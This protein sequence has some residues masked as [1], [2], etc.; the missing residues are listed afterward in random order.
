MYFYRSVCALVGA[1]SIAACFDATAPAGPDDVAWPT[2]EYAA[3][4]GGGLKLSVFEA[5]GD[6]PPFGPGWWWVG[7]VREPRT[8]LALRTFSHWEWCGTRLEAEVEREG[9][10]TNVTVGRVISVPSI[11][12][13]I[14][15]LDPSASYRRFLPFS[16]GEH[17]L[18]IHVL[19]QVHEYRVL[20]SP[21]AIDLVRVTPRLPA[22]VLRHV[23]VDEELQ[24]FWRFPPRSAAVVCQAVSESEGCGAL[25]DG[26]AAEPGFE[27]HYFPRW[28]Q[29]PFSGRVTENAAIESAVLGP[30]SEV[31]FFRYADAEGFA[32]LRQF[33]CGAAP[34]GSGRGA[35]AFSWRN[36]EVHSYSSSC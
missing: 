6:S 33:L 24:T 7:G 36:E 27:R 12:S 25:F 34:W 19:G 15:G 9:A 3:V 35:I 14:G 21:A 11:C 8:V 10:V 5:P 13:A 26:L 22:S 16:E 30:T 29:T 28:G 1:L 20:V 2:A 23:T 32:R 4:Y 17:T 31:A 18:R